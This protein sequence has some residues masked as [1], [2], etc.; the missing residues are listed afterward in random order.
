MII[1]TVDSGIL[2]FF[3]RLY[4]I[5]VFVRFDAQVPKSGESPSGWFPCPFD[6]S[7]S[8]LER[9]L[10][11][12]TRCFRLT[13]YFPCCLG[14][15]YFCKKPWSFLWGMILEIKIWVL[16]VLLSGEVSLLLD[17]SVDRA[18]DNIYV[19]S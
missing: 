13:L 1:I 19:S 3:S 12:R 15:S 16:R 4:S 8:V 6:L 7:P 14:I 18:G 5:L 11:V 9:F 2:F 10:A 17:L